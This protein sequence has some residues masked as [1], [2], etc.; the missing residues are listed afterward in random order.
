MA[1]PQGLVAAMGGGGGLG[2]PGTGGGA[3]AQV[4]PFPLLPPQAVL[5]SVVEQHH[6]VV[7]CLLLHHMVCN[8][9]RLSSV[10]GWAGYKHDC[11]EPLLGP[12]RRMT[13]AQRATFCLPVLKPTTA[14]EAVACVLLVLPAVL[15][16]TSPYTLATAAVWGNA[17]K[18]QFLGVMDCSLQC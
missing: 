14:I 8:V 6:A 4:V 3:R 17:R 11:S 5:A 1:Y 7:M 18:M 13:W 16:S 10:S 2:V 9:C 15:L 12:T